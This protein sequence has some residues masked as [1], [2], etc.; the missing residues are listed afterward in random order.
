MDVSKWNDLTLSF[1]H[2]KVTS[3]KISLKKMSR[4]I[5][6]LHS[7]FVGYCLAVRKHH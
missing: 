1:A 3:K 4:R 6:L 5:L 2:L 7:S